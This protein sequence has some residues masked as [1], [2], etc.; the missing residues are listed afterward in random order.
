MAG[1]WLGCLFAFYGPRRRQAWSIN[2]SLLCFAFT[3][4]LQKAPKQNMKQKR[5]FSRN[6]KEEQKLFVQRIFRG[7]SIGECRAFRF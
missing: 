6:L 1:N 3:L 2:N 5:G 7:Y 4:K